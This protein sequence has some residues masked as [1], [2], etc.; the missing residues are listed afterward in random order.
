MK[1]KAGITRCE[2]AIKVRIIN[3]ILLVS[4]ENKEYYFQDVASMPKKK[5]KFIKQNG[6]SVLNP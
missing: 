1:S 4:M 3:I 2:L 5:D 6:K